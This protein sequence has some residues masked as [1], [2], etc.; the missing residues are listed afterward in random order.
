MRTFVCGFLLLAMAMAAV[1]ADVTGKWSGT[2][3]ATSA[4]GGS[5]ES[6]V[7][8]I[9]KQNGTALTGSAGPDESQQWELANG[10]IDGNK[11][12]G[13]VQGSDGASYKLE[14]VEDGEHIKGDVAVTTAD[15]QPMHGKLDV[16]RMK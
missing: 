6:G 1:A 7:V 14:L 11:I 16:I 4:D 13:V 15:G 2:F 9:L 8:L 10:K 3:T 12:T 5:R